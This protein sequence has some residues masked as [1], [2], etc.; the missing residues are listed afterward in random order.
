MF[1]TTNKC[2]ENEHSD[3]VI[4]Q[5][6]SVMFND[7][8]W[9]TVLKH[10]KYTLHLCRILRRSE[11]KRLRRNTF[12][13]LLYTLLLYIPLNLT[14]IISSTYLLYIPHS[15]TRRSLRVWVRETQSRGIRY[16]KHSAM[17]WIDSMIIVRFMYNDNNLQQ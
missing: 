17:E 12:A 6:V 3:N 14:S 11:V 5:C 4:L 15:L 9:C 1:T 8:R 16:K 2:K 10:A 7:R 13:T